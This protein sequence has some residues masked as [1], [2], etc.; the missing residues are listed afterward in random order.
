MLVKT[1]SKTTVSAEKVRFFV[2][3]KFF[4]LQLVV[5][6]YKPVKQVNKVNKKKNLILFRMDKA[7]FYSNK[8]FCNH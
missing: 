4:L 1:V 5:I 7:T 6:K 2:D 3:R 8:L